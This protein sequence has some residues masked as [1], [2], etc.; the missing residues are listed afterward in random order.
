[1]KNRPSWLLRALLAGTAS[2]G[3]LHVGTCAQ[4]AQEAAVEGFFSATTPLL[5]DYFETQLGVDTSSQTS[6]QAA[7]GG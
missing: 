3:L 7:G 2:F 5:I 6:G 4:I 1:M